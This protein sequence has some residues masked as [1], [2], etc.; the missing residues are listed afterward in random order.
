M[1]RHWVPGNERAFHM[2][3]GLRR[4]GLGTVAAAATLALGSIG[5]VMSGTASAD[6]ELA[7]TAAPVVW[8]PCAPQDISN[9]PPADQA[10]F[11]C[12]NYVVPLDHRHPNRGT[13]NLA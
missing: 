11:S 5:S 9:V 6:P 7:A 8:G 2:R 12:A 1:W 3:A 13:I 10:K 4:R